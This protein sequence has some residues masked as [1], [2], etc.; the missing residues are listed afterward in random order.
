MQRPETSSIDPLCAQRIVPSDVRCGTC[1]GWHWL[2]GLPN[3]SMTGR[4]THPVRGPQRLLRGPADGKYCPDWQT[5]DP[6]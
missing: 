5:D 3:M 6:F 2:T 4:C 1:A